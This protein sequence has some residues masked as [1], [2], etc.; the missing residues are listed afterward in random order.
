MHIYVYILNKRATEKDNNQHYE[1]KIHSLH[2]SRGVFIVETCYI[3]TILVRIDYLPKPIKLCDIE[4]L[5]Y[6]KL[7]RQ[8]IIVDNRL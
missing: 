4:E 1:F 6:L 5:Y 7:A 8:F 2:H 3:V